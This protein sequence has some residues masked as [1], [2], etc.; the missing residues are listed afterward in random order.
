MPVFSL[1]S[2]YGIGSFGKTAKDFIDFLSEAG[3]SYWQVLPLG[4]TSF[5]DS[6]YMSFSAFAGNPYFIDLDTLKE[7]GL[8]TDTE[9]A[10]CDFGTDAGAVDYEALYKN[11]LALLRKAFERGRGL[12]KEEFQA[13]F[14]EN[15]S[16]IH[17]YALF[18]ALKKHFNES[19]WLN[20]PDEDIKLHK[21]FAWDRYRGELA[22]DF[23]FYGYLQ[24]LFYKQWGEIKGYANKKGIKIIGDIPIYVA[25]DSADVWSNPGYFQLDERNVPREVSGVPPDYF[26]ADGQL[27]GNPLYDYERMAEDNFAWWK[28]RLEGAAKLYDVIRIDHFRGFE[29]YWKVPYGETTAKNGKWVKGPG[30]ALVGVLKDFKGMEIIAEDLGYPSKEVANL[31]EFSGFPGMKLLEC[32]F[33]SD[34]TN[35]FLPHNY[36]AKCVCYNG[37]HD[38]HS[39]MGWVETAPENHIQFALRYFG[40]EDRGDMLNT[41]I[42][43]GMASVADLYIVQ[44]QDW[45]GLG[46]EATINT[47]GTLGNNWVW[48]APAGSFDKKLA[49]KIAALTEIYGRKNNNG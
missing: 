29:S 2:P 47:P 3:Q 21:G 14:C 48:R 9:I 38:N 43:Y 37:T 24:Y 27:W 34:S 15:E 41:M 22:E 46:K 18:M 49:E 45:L 13:F 23:E 20:W 36:S 6:P 40:I 7:D 1:P 32:A 35:P 26:N 10:G 11:R 4:P 8:L 16:W 5:G 39:V 30:K 31:L 17:D 28:R 19:S 25:L 42:R 44:F 12:N 33:E